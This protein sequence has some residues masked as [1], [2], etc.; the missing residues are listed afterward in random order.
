MSGA[1]KQALSGFLILQKNREKI[2]VIE[3]ELQATGLDYL[4]GICKYFKNNDLQRSL[5]RSDFGTKHA[6]IWDEW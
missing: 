2:Q 3:S 1:V 6:S 4:A 5:G